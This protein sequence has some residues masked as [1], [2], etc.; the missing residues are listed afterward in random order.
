M[1]TPNK[2]TWC[3]GHWLGCIPPL[4]AE[5]EWRSEFHQENT[6]VRR[7]MLVKGAVY[8]INSHTV[9]LCWAVATCTSTRHVICM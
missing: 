9:K 1:N 7:T 3:G 5:V 8:E 2:H 6:Y 4:E